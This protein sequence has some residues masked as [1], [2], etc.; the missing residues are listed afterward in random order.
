MSQVVRA[1]S[2]WATRLVSRWAPG[3]HWADELDFAGPRVRT[4]GWAWGLLA[5]GVW[6][7]VVVVDRGEQQEQSI[8]D[9]QAQLKRLTLADRQWR[10]ARAAS[11]PRA[12]A[13]ANASGADAPP[14]SPAAWPEAATMAAL[15]AYPWQAALDGVAARAADHQVVLTALA[16]DL[17][18]WD[19]VL[20][21]PPTMRV[22]AAVPSDDVALRWAAAL[23]QGQ[24][25]ARSA[26]A[27]PFSTAK[28][29]YAL[30]VEAQARWVPGAVP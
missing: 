24:L 29:S 27:K 10:L 11:T 2:V 18:A 9:A 16:L 8:L 15:L 22:L 7:L 13:G 21:P 26:L 1:V 12:A 30:K 4:A 3:A 6:A 19:P 25:K 17:S 28:A 14:L 23:P 5:V 20:A